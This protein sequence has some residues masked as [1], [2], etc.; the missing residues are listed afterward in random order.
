MNQTEK[1]IELYYCYELKNT[2]TETVIP[3]LGTPPEKHA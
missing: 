2:I 1:Q 3:R